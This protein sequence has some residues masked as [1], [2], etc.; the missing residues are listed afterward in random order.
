MFST[1]SKTVA[2]G[3]TFSFCSGFTTSVHSLYSS[4]YADDPLPFQVLTDC[5][6][7]TV[8]SSSKAPLHWQLGF[9]RRFCQPP[10]LSLED[11]YIQNRIFSLPPRNM[12]SFR[13]SCRPA[14]FICFFKGRM[15]VYIPFI[16]CAGSINNPFFLC[17]GQ[18]LKIPAQ[19]CN[20]FFRC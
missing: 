3:W 8:R 17:A 13:F 16:P 11:A 9:T 20:C 10:Q 19:T 2:D 6:R 5:R 1:A 15:P 18:T 4:G 7:Q 14:H 12:F